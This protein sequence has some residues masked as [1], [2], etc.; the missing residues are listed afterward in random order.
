[1]RLI[2]ALLASLRIA[3]VPKVGMAYRYEINGPFE[4]G[5]VLTPK[6]LCQG[7]VLYEVVY[8]NGSAVETACSFSTFALM[9]R[10][11]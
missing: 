6:N 7:Y 3:Y 1:M 10:E 8:E 2:R 4:I 5:P 11:A 9:C